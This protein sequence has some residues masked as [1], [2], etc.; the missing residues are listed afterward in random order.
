MRCNNVPSR[1]AA[2]TPNRCSACRAGMANKSRRIFCW[3]A[4]ARSSAA[5]ARSSAAFARSFAASALLTAASKRLSA[6][7]RA[8][9]SSSGVGRSRPLEGSETE[10]NSPSGRPQGSPLRTCTGIQGVAD[11]LQGRRSFVSPESC[12]RF[13]ASHRPEPRRFP[14]PQC[15]QQATAGGAAFLARSDLIAPR[16]LVEGVHQFR[17]LLP[18]HGRR[19]G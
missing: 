3:A 13:G 5:F 11:L 15:H 7:S 12:S 16:K 6:S 8:A 14:L 9:P 17:H 1:P 4:L 10:G 2:C 19:L 18:Q